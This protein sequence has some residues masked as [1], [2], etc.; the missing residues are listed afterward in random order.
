ASYSSAQ[1]AFARDGDFLIFIA[2]TLP[3]VFLVQLVAKLFPALKAAVKVSIQGGASGPL[4]TT[5]CRPG[6][7]S[8]NITGREYFGGLRPKLWS[9]CSFGRFAAFPSRRWLWTPQALRDMERCGP[10]PLPLSG[11]KRNFSIEDTCCSRFRREFA[12]GPLQ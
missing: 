5:D 2:L 11:C 1:T 10:L 7:S 12:S 4:A 6:T 9:L 3:L 8:A